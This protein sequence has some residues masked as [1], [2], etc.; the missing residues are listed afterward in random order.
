MRQI[1]RFWILGYYVALLLPVVLVMEPVDVLAAA[2]GAEGAGLAEVQGVAIVV[3]AVGVVVIVFDYYHRLLTA[4]ALYL[5]SSVFDALGYV[6]LIGTCFEAK[7]TGLESVV[8]KM[9]FWQVLIY[10]V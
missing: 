5:N 4:H 1:L 8:R 10:A 6:Y 9:C 2:E 7:R 3:V